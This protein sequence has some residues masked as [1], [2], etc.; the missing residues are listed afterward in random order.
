MSFCCGNCVLL[1]KCKSYFSDKN[2]CTYIDIII[3]LRKKCNLFD[4]DFNNIHREYYRQNLY[5]VSE[6]LRQL[7]LVTYLT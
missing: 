1:P 5:K 4:N 7:I 6:E 3:I 2:R